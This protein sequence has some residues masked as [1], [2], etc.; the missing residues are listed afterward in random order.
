MNVERGQLSDG[1]LYFRQRAKFG[2]DV[3]ADQA[4][5]DRDHQEHRDRLVASPDRL[6]RE[7]QRIGDRHQEAQREIAVHDA[8]SD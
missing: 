7:P 5:R 1:L 6:A 2:H 4:E 8:K 3:V